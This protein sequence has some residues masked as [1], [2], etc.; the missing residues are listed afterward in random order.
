MSI[1]NELRLKAATDRRFAKL[2][3]P[4][5][6][7]LEERRIN[8]RGNT[9]RCKSGLCFSDPVLE[10]RRMARSSANTENSSLESGRGRF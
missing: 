6:R 8:P 2:I 10:P 7:K 9:C 4:S 5:G 3:A 1:L